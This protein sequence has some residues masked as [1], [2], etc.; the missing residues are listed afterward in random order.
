MIY[1]RKLLIAFI[2]SCLLLTSQSTKAQTVLPDF[3]LTSE[4]GINLLSWVCQYDGIKSIAVQRSADSIFN[5]ATIGYVKNIA[6]GSQGYIDGHPL[7]GMNY[8]RLYIVFSSDI[9][10][11]SNRGKIFID[12]AALLQK[13]VLPPNDSLQKMVTKVV[14]D[15]PNIII[16]PPDPS[17][18][19]TYT[20]VRSQFVFTNPFTGHI[21]IELPEN[22][23]SNEMYS[24]KFF[25]SKDKKTV[26]IPRISEREVVLDKRNF[27]RKGIYKF[28]LYKNEK[29]V[30][31][32][33]I[34]IY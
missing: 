5:Y 23:N 34:T 21:N 14:T 30:E 4:K 6:K 17:N 15:D 11:T 33:H 3:T 9:T 16:A 1:H 20:Y 8:Y 25:D 13:T 27:Q 19:N 10:W 29:L 28:E 31:K 22:F 18:M 26:E 32:G 7:P 2:W 24:L 12:S